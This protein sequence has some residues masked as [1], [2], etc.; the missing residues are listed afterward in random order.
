MEQELKNMENVIDAINP[1]L[2]KTKELRKFDGITIECMALDMVDRG[3]SAEEVKA[4]C[5]SLKLQPNTV[6]YRKDDDKLFIIQFPDFMPYYTDEQQEKM[7]KDTFMFLFENI[8]MKD[9]A[10]ATKS[11]LIENIDS[12]VKHAITIY[13]RSN[14]N[15]YKESFD[16]YY[17]NT[18]YRA[19]VNGIFL[20]SVEEF[21]G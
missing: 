17:K 8:K 4:V 15:Q 19:K 9:P 21:L 6:E 2:H 18:K 14:I 3:V 11:A 1:Q 13:C 16:T 20:V 5:D 10:S 12:I 7:Y